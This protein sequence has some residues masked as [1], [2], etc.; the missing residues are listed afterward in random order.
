MIDY[1]T[2]HNNT[3]LK[4]LNTDITVTT[5]ANGKQVHE[6]GQP[7]VCSSAVG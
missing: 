4:L 3:N 2:Y 7:Q 6:W 1:L 5:E